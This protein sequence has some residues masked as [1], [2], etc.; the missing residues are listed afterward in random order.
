MQKLLNV[1]VLWFNYSI[2]W[3]VKYPTFARD[4]WGL[5]GKLW[6]DWF[7][8]MRLK[9]HFTQMGRVWGPI[10][11]F[12][13][14]GEK[15]YHNTITFNEDYPQNLTSKSIVFILPYISHTPTSILWWNKVLSLNRNKDA[16]S[17]DIST[18]SPLN[19]KATRNIFTSLTIWPETY[20]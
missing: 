6:F 1:A 13:I 5:V 8:Q 11:V 17:T 4:D 2:I 15:A 3:A 7:W 16:T 19:H 18:Q 14:F 9:F 20:F 12:T 10:T